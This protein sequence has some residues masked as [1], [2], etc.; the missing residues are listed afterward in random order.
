LKLATFVVED[1]ERI[2]AVSPGG[3]IAELPDFPNML[4]AIEAGIPALQKARRGKNHAL[5]DVK[6][7]AP[8]PRPPRI[9]DFLCFELHVR[10]SRA[11]RYLFGMGTER[12]DPAKVDIAKV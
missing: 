4:A 12:I 8:I 10:Q 1:Q 5:K 2:G 6:L 7:L 9:R 11:N 3:E